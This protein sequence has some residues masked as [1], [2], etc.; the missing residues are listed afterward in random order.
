MR[1]FATLEQNLIAYCAPTLAGLKSANLFAHHFISKEGFFSELLAVNE[2]LNV[3]GV[4]VMTL[5]LHEEFALIYVFRKSYLEKELQRKDARLLLEEYG[6]Q[7]DDVEDCLHQLRGRLS[8][9]CCTGCFPHEIGVFLG[10]PIEDVKGFIQK[11]GKEC[12]C[13]GLWKVYG[14]EEKARV[15]FA[16]LEKC[17]AVYKEVF[18]GGRSLVQMTVCA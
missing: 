13:C 2:A 6:Y 3:R 7:A 1:Q 4:T 11:G 16:K 17:T 5:A 8:C 9:G 12:K 15:L 10:Y 18:A 14:D